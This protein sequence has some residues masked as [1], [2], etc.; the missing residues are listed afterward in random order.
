[1]NEEMDAIKKSV[2]K[3]G[4]SESEADSIYDRRLVS[5]LRK[6]MLYDQI[7]A[8]DIESKRLKQTPPKSVPSNA[9]NVHTPKANKLAELKSKQA[10][11]RGRNMKES[12][13]LIKSILGG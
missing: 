11:N 2:I 10:K 13:A 5:L 7:Q 8:Q 6:A 9:K 1:M 12:H 3:S 4:F